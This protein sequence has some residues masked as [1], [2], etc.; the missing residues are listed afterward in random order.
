M[1]AFAIA[2]RPAYA[3]NTPVRDAKYRALIRTLPCA[4]CGAHWGIE[5]AHTGPHGMS[6]KSSDLDCIPLC[7]KHHR[8]GADAL[9]SLGPV[10]FARVHALDVP[11]LIAWRRKLFGVGL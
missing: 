8:T 11:A 7:R 1:T 10:K 3:R 9:H 4:V 5:A 2:P 6:Q